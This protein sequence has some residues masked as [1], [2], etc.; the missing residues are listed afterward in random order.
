[1][2]GMFIGAVAKHR[3]VKVSATVKAEVTAR[4]LLHAKQALAAGM[5]DRIA[6]L[7]DTLKRLGAK[8]VGMSGKPRAQFGA[9]AATTTGGENGAVAPHL[10]T[11]RA[12]DVAPDPVADVCPD[13]DSPLDDEGNCTS[14]DYTKPEATKPAATPAPTSAKTSS[15][16]AD[17]AAAVIGS[18]SPNNRPIE[19]KEHPVSQSTAAPDGVEVNAA[20]AA[21]RTRGAGIRAL[22]KKHRVSDDQ[23]EAMVS[24]GLTLDQASHRILGLVEARSAGSATIHVGDSRELNKPF[25]SLGEQL[26]AIVA[27]SSLGRDL[28]LKRDPRLAAATGAGATV[29]S[30]GAFAIQSDIAVDLEKLAFETGVLANQC[31]STEISANGDGLEVT[32][33]DETSRATGSRWGGVQVYRGAEADVATATKPKFGL[34][35]S[36]LS[37]MIGLYY[38]TDRLLQDAAALSSVASEAFASEFGFKLDDEIVN[39]TGGPQ[40]LGI[41][42]APARVSVTKESGQAAATI[43]AAN[44]QKMWLRMPARWR[45]TASWFINQEVEAQL[46]NMQIGL[47]VAGALVYMP[48][49][50]LSGVPYGTIYGRPVVPIEQAAALGTEGDIIFFAPQQYKL[51]R[52]GG[53]QS[54]MSIHVKFTSNERCFRWI[55][56]V[57]GAPKLKSAITPYKG[58]ATLSSMVTLATRA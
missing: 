43:V 36:R 15:A 39:G 24:E 54:D 58:S 16:R 42:N 27:E 32:Y 30:D 50:G 48:P 38:A 22:G 49:G 53:L 23:I 5:I 2:Y 35:E 1:M 6:T 47:G 17:G 45:T 40:C 51:I 7:E 14:C 12:D 26:Q 56:R 8:D 37:D 34:W 31:S 57:N 18:I 4:A 21:E 19:A 41:L 55:M 25:A 44:I 10:L 11:A 20:I 33:I 28:G 46:Q 3:G 13:C 52:K 9:A 29:G